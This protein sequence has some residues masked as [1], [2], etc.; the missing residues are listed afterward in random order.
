[1]QMK[2]NKTPQRKNN[3]HLTGEQLLRKAVTGTIEVKTP[4]Q[5]LEEKVSNIMDKI[6]QKAV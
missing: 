5:I 1:M 2:Q 3:R 6:V 4:N